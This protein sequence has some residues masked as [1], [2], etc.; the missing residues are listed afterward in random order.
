MWCKR[1][2]VQD[3]LTFSVIVSRL[4]GSMSPRD[5][6]VFPTVSATLDAVTL[7]NYQP[8]EVVLTLKSNNTNNYKYNEG[9]ANNFWQS[10][11]LKPAGFKEHIKVCV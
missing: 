6:S 9:V 10:N 3:S 1:A 7:N 4:L 2:I 11:N 5:V 8:N